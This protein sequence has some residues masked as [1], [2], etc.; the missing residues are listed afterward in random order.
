MDEPT[1]RIAD[2]EQRPAYV[3]TAGGRIKRYDPDK[4]KKGKGKQTTLK[5]P[6]S[7]GKGTKKK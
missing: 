4:K 5:S 3:A 7:K 1:K 6:K 2:S